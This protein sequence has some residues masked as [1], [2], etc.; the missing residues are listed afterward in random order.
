MSLITSL[1][2]AVT[3]D[4]NDGSFSQSFTAVRKWLVDWKLE[5]LSTLQV[6]VTPGP[7]KWAHLTRGKDRA[8]H[9]T[10]VIVQKHVDPTVNTEPDALCAFLEELVAYYRTKAITTA[11][12]DN[13]RCLE[14]ELVPG[15]AAAVNQDLLAN[16]HVF[17]GVLRATWLAL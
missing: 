13:L 1:A 16:A 11:G 15:S 14:R 6:V 9:A 10:D 12:G 5:D 8:D 3:A 17:T 2:D 7:S 4:L